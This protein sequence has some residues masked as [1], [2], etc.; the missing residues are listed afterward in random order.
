M[1]FDETVQGQKLTVRN[2]I[3][4]PTLLLG[5]LV[6]VY[7]NCSTS[8]AVVAQVAEIHGNIEGTLHFKG[9]VL[10]VMP[11][12]TIKNGAD[13]IAQSFVNEGKIEGEISQTTQVSSTPSAN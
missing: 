1:G 12:S 11:T 13:V 2:D 5:Q 8:L 4:K 10:R 9:Q 3:T 7:G 6:Q